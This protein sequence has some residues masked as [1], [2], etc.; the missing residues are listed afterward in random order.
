MTF[1]THLLC[2][3]H[4]ILGHWEHSSEQIREIDLTSWGWYSSVGD[5][6]ETETNKSRNLISVMLRAF[7]QTEQ[8]N[9]VECQG[10]PC[11]AHKA[12]REKVYIEIGTRLTRWQL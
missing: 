8:G 9:Q 7:K 2:A 1:I 5:G 3:G 12:S 6:Q 4:C 10:F 11:K